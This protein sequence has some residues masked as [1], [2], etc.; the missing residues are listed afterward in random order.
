MMDDIDQLKK[1][2]EKPPEEISSNDAKSCMKKWLCRGVGVGAETSRQSKIFMILLKTF[3]TLHLQSL[4]M[5]LR[6]RNLLNLMRRVL[7]SLILLMLD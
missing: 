1:I 4:S 7:K 6:L 3:I 2:A 5:M